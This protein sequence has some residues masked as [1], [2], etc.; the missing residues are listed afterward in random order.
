MLPEHEAK[1]HRY[2]LHYDFVLKESE[3]M[4]RCDIHFAMGW[5][6]SKQLSLACIFVI[7]LILG[8]FCNVYGDKENVK[9][10]NDADVINAVT[11]QAKKLQKN[12]RFWVVRPCAI[13][14]SKENPQTGEMFIGY[15]TPWYSFPV[16]NRIE[17]VGWDDWIIPE[18]TRFGILKNYVIYGE[19]K[20]EKWFIAKPGDGA[21]PEFFRNKDTWLEELVELGGTDTPEMVNIR[22]GYHNAQQS[23]WIG[24]IASGAFVA[25]IVSLPW[26]ITRHLRLRKKLKKGAKSSSK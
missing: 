12:R 23:L 1:K 11:E 7:I 10:L 13:E 5:N 3:S 14:W 9:N 18:I 26:M 17:R 15:S 20:D 21:L 16:P 22:E 19:V 6:L 4:T 8:N 24:R 2:T 25:G